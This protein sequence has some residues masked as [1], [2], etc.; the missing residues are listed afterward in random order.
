MCKE[1]APILAIIYRSSLATGIVPREWKSANVAPIFKK[2]EHY[3]PA[4]YRPVSLTSVPCKIMEH[5][6]VSQMMSHLE[7]NNILTP[8]QHGFRKGHSCETQLLELTNDITKCLDEG[9]Q[10]DIII[11]DF[12]KAFDKVNH[13]LLVMK[14]D[15]YGIRGTIN[16]WIKDFL[17]NRQQTV[18]VEGSTSEPAGVKSGVPQ[19]SVLG[20][21]LFLVYI[22]DLPAKVESDS[23]LF[24]D[25]T[26]VDRKIEA[27][28][29][30]V[31]LQSDLTSLEKWEAMWDMAFHALKCIV[32]TAC[33]GKDPII[34]DYKLHGQTL[35]RVRSTG[36]LGLTIQSDGQWTEHIEA[37]AL[38]GNRLLGFLRRNLKIGSKAIKEQAYKMLL[39]PCLE[40]ACTVWD[41]HTDTECAKL[42]RIQRRAARWVMNRHRNT[43]SV[44]EMLQ[45][46]EW[47]TL[48]NRRQRARLG[49]LY[50][51][52]DESVCMKFTDDLQQCPQRPR[53]AA[54]K[55]PN[56][57]QLVRKFSRNDYRTMAFLP[58]TI[59]EWNSLS[60]DT[61]AAP[62]Y[63]AFCA[64]L[65][66][67]F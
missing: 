55:L 41:P 62:S 54:S 30:T 67:L 14:L 58:R 31:I 39:R 25:D 6:L 16:R 46:L 23:R 29:D 2:G 21:C 26:A 36:Y 27:T 20:P 51:V 15:H 37:I 22:N 45:T 35:E 19:G 64:R 44:G 65:S 17:A 48:A 66:R 59:R 53:R 18:V 8:Q 24:A 4:N 63:D 32:L 3:N 7:R 5:I 9:H 50:K 49:M 11:L 61:V 56:N 57:R 13:S 1:L 10:R 38:K 40:Y 52:L 33:R 12:A 43:S 28:P 42:E 60:Q 47:P 34:A